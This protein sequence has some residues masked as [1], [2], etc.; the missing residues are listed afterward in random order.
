MLSIVPS[1]NYP[2]FCTHRRGG[3]TFPDSE[4]LIRIASLLRLVSPFFA[5][6][7]HQMEGFRVEGGRD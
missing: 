5:L 4:D 2:F 1:T 7:T 6:I 3:I